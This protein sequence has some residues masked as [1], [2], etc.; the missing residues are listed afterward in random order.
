MINYTGQFLLSS[1]ALNGTDFEEAMLFI[2]EDNE[3]GS[4]GFIINKPFPR[5]LNELEEFK[6]SLPF[7]LYTGGP[8]ATGGIFMLHR[9]PDIIEDGRKIAEGIFLGGNIQQ[10]V[11]AINRQTITEAD[12][13]LFIGY[14][15]WDAGQ[16]Q[17]EKEEGSW[18]T[19]TAVEPF[20][21]YA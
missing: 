10:A 4:T 13:K 16:L 17:E 8:V 2:I 15:G 5:K 6:K 19:C 14:C 11:A 7:P 9:R 20:S 1:P 12:I 18:I 3:K 21:H